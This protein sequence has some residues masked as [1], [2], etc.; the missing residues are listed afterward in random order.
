V[1]NTEDAALGE[2]IFA[3]ISTDQGEIVT[4]LE[5]EKTPLTVCSFVALAEGKMN[6]AQDKPFY[7]G[8]SFHRV[9]PD[10]MIQGGDP[11]GNGTGGPGYQFPDEIESSLRHDG[12]GVLSMAN[13]GPGTNGSQFFITHV[14]TPWLDGR[15]TV[16][17]RVV[18]GQEVVDAIKQGDKIQSVRIIR[19]GE[20]A[21]AFRADQETFDSLLRNASAAEKAKEKAQRDADMALIRSQYPNAA[22]SPSGV[23]YEILA[24]GSGPKPSAGNTVRMNYRGMFLDGRVFDSSDTQ[25]APLEFPV[26]VGRVLQGFD[27]TALDMR[28][29]EKRLVVI[30]PE[31]AYGERG[32]GGV[33]PPNSFLAFEMELVEIIQE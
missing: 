1:E 31:L 11:L 14:E 12:P 22:S 15:H 19:N 27:E 6:A 28:L 4:R 2:G 26:G 5:Y 16:F 20:S 30:P 13:A 7:D 17:G 10:F 25:G 29:G 18:S 3:R 32:A 21:A 8:L 24:E 33:I 9:I 23:F